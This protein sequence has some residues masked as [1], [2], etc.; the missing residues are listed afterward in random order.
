MKKWNIRALALTVSLMLAMGLLL[1]GCGGAGG[2]ANKEIAETVRVAALNGPTGMGMVDLMENEMVEVT[3]YQAPDEAVQ[4]LIAGE[5]DIAAVPSNLAPVLYNK[6]EGK[7]V[8][9]TTIA[10]GILYLVEN[11]EA[12]GSIE[13]LKGMTIVASGKGG[14]PE[15]VLTLLLE[16]AGLKPG[17]DVEI[18]WMDVHADVAQALL[19]TPGTVALLPEP[20]VS[21]VLSK[22]ET[23]RVA[24]D[25]NAAWQEVYGGSLPMGV[26]I[27]KK[28]FVESRPE[29]TA[30]FLANLS[31]S[32]DDVNGASDEVADK[33][34]AAGFLADPEIA[35]AAIPRCNITCMNPEESKA[36][37]EGFYQTLFDVAPASVGGALPGEDFYYTVK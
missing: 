27:A 22:S 32:V 16:Q 18:K 7:I 5:V 11:G 3:T 35:K 6:T 34:V 37:L 15:Y 20:F 21:T 26:V 29:D 31:D 9:L 12:V 17:T 1:T 10:S 36:V 25:L 23:A 19:K 13:D 24:V 4:K 30:A 14:T 33:I 28:D 2:A 8:A